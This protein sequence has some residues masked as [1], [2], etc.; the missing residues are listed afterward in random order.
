[1]SMQLNAMRRLPGQLR[2][3]A[4]STN[5]LSHLTT[6]QV[7]R[8]RVRCLGDPALVRRPADRTRRRSAHET[9]RTAACPSAMQ[10]THPTA[11]RSGDYQH[12]GAVALRRA[13]SQRVGILVK[14]R[15]KRTA[16]AVPV[17]RPA[18][19]IPKN[20]FP[21][22]GVPVPGRESRHATR[23]QP[24]D[25]SGLLGDGG[26]RHP[27]FGEAPLWPFAPAR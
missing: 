24:L 8:P 7:N 19:R 20:Q 15:S 5:E 11:Y 4:R 9:I 22:R 17:G 6:L 26:N 27:A 23:C 3:S 14:Q 16:N 21:H 2:D 13:R 25:H 1:M 10:R 18:T 12:D